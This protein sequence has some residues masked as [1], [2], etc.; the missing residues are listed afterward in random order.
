MVHTLRSFYGY[1]GNR[2][3]VRLWIPRSTW[4]LRRRIPTTDL[5][6]TRRG[7]S[8]GKSCPRPPGRMGVPPSTGRAIHGP[9]RSIN[10]SRRTSRLSNAYGKSDSS[11]ATASGEPSGIPR[12][13]LRA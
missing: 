2:D 9:P 4:A 5:V 8:C 3:L 7:C 11:L 13:F 6:P 1:L 12:G 10:S